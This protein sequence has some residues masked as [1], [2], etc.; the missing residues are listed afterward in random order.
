M[1]IDFLHPALLLVSDKTFE[2]ISDG[3]CKY[4]Y[5]DAQFEM[6]ARLSARIFAGYI[7]GFVGDEVHIPIIA[8]KPLDW[9]PKLWELQSNVLELAISCKSKIEVTSGNRPGQPVHITN[10]TALP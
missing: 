4:S 8:E 2:A 3:F 7:R 6:F 9:I 5:D 10:F 1:P